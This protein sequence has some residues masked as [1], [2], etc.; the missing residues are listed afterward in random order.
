MVESPTEQKHEKRGK[1]K[2]ATQHGWKGD[3]ME[4]VLPEL[5][6]LNSYIRAERSNR[7]TAAK[8]KEDQTELVEWHCRNQRLPQLTKIE[9]ITFIWRHKNRRKDFDNVE[10]SQKFIR[11]GLV[12]A[13]VIPNDGWEHFPPR[14][15][16]KHEVDPNR[17]G[18]TVIIK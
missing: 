9:K 1:K 18:V 12:K 2:V 4:L 13:G 14:T 11:D 6:D 8:I 17:A 16:H 10:F 15:L 3:T 5:V 7:H